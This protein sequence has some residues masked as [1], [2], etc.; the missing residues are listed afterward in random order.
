MKIHF[1]IAVLAITVSCNSEP[2]VI[3]SES[4]EHN[5]AVATGDTDNTAPAGDVHQIVVKDILQTEKY[6]YLESKEGAEKY[7]VAIPRR[8]DIEVGATYLYQGGLMKTNFKSQEYDRVFEK[9][10]L[11]SGVTA[12]SGSTG[13]GS[14]VDRALAKAQG[15]NVNN[16]P[17]GSTLR[18]AVISISDI[19]DKRTEYEGKVVAVTGECVKINKMIMGRNWVHLVDPSVR[20]KDI[21]LTVTTTEDVPV[22]STVTMQGTIVLNRDFGSGYKYEVIMEGAT[23]L[24]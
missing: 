5:H 7:W 17:E 1:L 4:N 18:G 3:E 8:D 16:S 11:V 21:D 10:Y 24:R 12:A 14:A 2:K 6:T 19:L 9:V 23:I 15:G 13:T 20:G 22:G